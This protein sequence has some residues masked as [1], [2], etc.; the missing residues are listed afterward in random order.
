MALFLSESLFAVGGLGHVKS[1][2]TV[3]EVSNKLTLSCDDEKG[4]NVLSQAIY[5]NLKNLWRLTGLILQ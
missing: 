1:A 4:P 5:V 2:L 3:E